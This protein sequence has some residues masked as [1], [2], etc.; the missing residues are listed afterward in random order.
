MKKRSHKNRII[1]LMVIILLAAV[2]VY[3]GTELKA[4]N[5]SEA[6]AKEMVTKLENIIPGLGSPSDSSGG[7]GRDPLAAYIM[8]DYNVVGCLEIPALDLML[9]V[10]LKSE[11]PKAE[12]QS[13][14]V[15][16][17]GGSPVKGQFRL[18]SD[19]MGGFKSIAGLRPGENVIFTDID[20]VRYEYTVTT[21]YHLKDW[22]EGDNDL[23]L[24]YDTDEVTDFVVGC[25]RQ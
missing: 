17:E 5:G 22:D 12:V 16:F 4:G 19:S 9:P 8:G 11:D 21:Q 7:N 1:I 15:Y 25:T 6:E 2:L 18:K 24:C 13:Y 14:L 23:L 20:G 10:V 3:L